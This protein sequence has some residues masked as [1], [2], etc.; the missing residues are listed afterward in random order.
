MSEWEMMYGTER[1][2]FNFFFFRQRLNREH[3]LLDKKAVKKKSPLICKLS[4][5]NLE[6]TKGK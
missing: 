6:I 3:R 4:R 5:F 1:T 2:Y